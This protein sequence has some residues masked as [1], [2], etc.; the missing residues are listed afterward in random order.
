MDNSSPDRFNIDDQAESLKDLDVSNYTK[1]Q[2]QDT[3]ES[4]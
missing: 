2:L 1:R 4:L 3:V